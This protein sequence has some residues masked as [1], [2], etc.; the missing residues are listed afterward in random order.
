[1]VVKFYICIS[2]KVRCLGIVEIP[3]SKQ[4]LSIWSSRET[5]YCQIEC[6]FVS[7]KLNGTDRSLTLAHTNRLISATFS[8]TKQMCL[9]LADK[10]V[11]YLHL[12][13]LM[14]IATRLTLVLKGSFNQQGN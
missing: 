14:I 12:P 10:T 3:T 9:I 2:P 1:M 4:M 8:S 13:A 11:S 5:L 7:E 6:P